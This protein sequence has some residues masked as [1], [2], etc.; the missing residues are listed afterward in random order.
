MQAI[1]DACQAKQLNAM[2]ALVISNN[3]KS[4]AIAR[5]KKE[6][7]AF[8]HLS[9]TTHPDATELSAA[10]LH[11]LQLHQIDLIILAGYMKLLPKAIITKYADRILNIHPALLPKYGGQGF[12]GK[13]VHQAPLDAKEPYTGITIHLVNEK[14]DEGRIINQCTI[15]I[16]A[17]DTV[18]SLSEKVLA[19]EHSFFVETLQLILNGEI[20]IG[21]G[22]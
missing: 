5:A 6:K 19:K 22:A 4:G 13:N 9:A 10:M 21:S 20:K 3:A 2:P 14:Y 16:L 17:A 11:K 18:E 7:I 8:Y 12:Y 1:I 15:P